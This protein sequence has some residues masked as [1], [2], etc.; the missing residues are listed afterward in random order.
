MHNATINTFLLKQVSQFEVSL[1]KEHLM[2]PMICE[3]I[4]PIPLMLVNI[5][6]MVRWE[7]QILFKFE[8]L[9]TH[10]QKESVTVCLSFG[11]WWCTAGISNTQ[12]LTAC[13]TKLC[14]NND[15]SNNSRSNN[16]A[17]SNKSKRLYTLLYP[18]I[19]LV[20]MCLV[21]AL[22]TSHVILKDPQYGMPGI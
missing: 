20:V 7:R 10:L 12:C 16:S 22:M 11:I 6:H 2:D 19:Q 15:N 5:L 21:V 1:R 13:V 3:C 18:V 14:W 4:L 8:M 9:L 17:N